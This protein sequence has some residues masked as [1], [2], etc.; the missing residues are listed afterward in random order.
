MQKSNTLNIIYIYLFL[1]FQYYSCHNSSRT[2]WL[3]YNGS[4]HFFKKKIMYCS[5]FMWQN[6]NKLHN[7]NK[8]SSFFVNDVCSRIPNICFTSINSSYRNNVSLPI[9]NHSIYMIKWSKI[10]QSTWYREVTLSLSIKKT[11]GED[12]IVNLC[13]WNKRSNVLWVSTHFKT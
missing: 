7:N 3:L 9:I 1:I 8:K 11:D 6:S 4:S 13:F 10:T 12:M 5:E 2:Q